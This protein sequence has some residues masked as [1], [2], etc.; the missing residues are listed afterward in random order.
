MFG[1]LGP[2]GAGQIHDG[3][4]PHDALPARRRD[5]RGWPGSTC[6]AAGRRAPGDRRRRPE[7]RLRPRRH[8]AART[9]SCRPS[10]TGSPA[11]ARRADE[12]LERFGL[13]DAADRQVKTYS[14]GMQRR[15]DVALGLIHRP[16]VLFLD[17]PTTGPRP[18]GAGADV[19]RDRA[20]RARGADD[21][22]AHHALPRGGRPARLA[23]GD[24]RPRP[25]RRARHAG[26]AEGRAGGR[27]GAGRAGR[28]TTAAPRGRR[29][30]ASAGWPTC[31][32]EGRTLHARA[33]NGA[34][35]IPAVLAALEAH[36]VRAASVTLARPSLDDVYLRHAGRAYA[37]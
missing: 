12:L 23:A 17:E 13:A 20:A 24:R 27:R 14:G 21:D 6:C 29:W 1:L 4:H 33:A 25:D 34:A 32:V 9:S 11:R 19:G 30:S 18:G 36:G 28:P 26:R 15:L 35:A 31:C 5:A 37:A 3:P 16:Q 7:A 22:P 10:S 2:N 8:R